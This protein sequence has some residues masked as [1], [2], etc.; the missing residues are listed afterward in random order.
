MSTLSARQYAQ[1]EE[2]WKRKLQ[3]VKTTAKRR[4]K[5]DVSYPMEART[6][7]IASIRRTD[8]EAAYREALRRMGPKVRTSGARTRRAKPKPTVQPSYLETAKARRAKSRRPGE[9]H[10]DL[11]LSPF[12]RDWEIKNATDVARAVLQV[13]VG[14]AAGPK[15]GAIKQ[16]IWKRAEALSATD[17]VPPS[18]K[19]AR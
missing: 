5:L 15:E 13:E 16:W 6:L 1:A 7:A 17:L 2:R 12:G 4:P 14:H 8:G 3:K 9:A 18:W 10:R 11:V 19:R